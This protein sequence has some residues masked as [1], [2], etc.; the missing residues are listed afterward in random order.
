[1]R[2]APRPIALA[3]AVALFF[4]TSLRAQAP[5]VTKQSVLLGFN[6]GDDYCLA[7]YKQLVAYWERLQSESDRIKLVRFGTTEEGRP[8]MMAIVTSPANHKKL[9]HYRDIAR[10]LCKVEVMAEN[11]ARALAAEGKAVVWIDAGLHANKSLC[12]Q[13]MIETIY[14]LVSAD[15]AET[16]RVLDDVIILF[17]HANPDGQDLVADWYMRESDPKKRSLN[18]LPKLYEKYAGH[19]NNRDF[20]ACN[21]AETRNMNRVMYHEWFPQIVYNHHQ[22]GPPGTVLF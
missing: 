18:G 1:M 16:K 20:Y 15:D 3:V 14:Q 6:I 8:Q 12:A 17:V 21:L 5:R 7:N 2:A 22:A 10:K 9:D 13:M 19:D 4:T 11:E